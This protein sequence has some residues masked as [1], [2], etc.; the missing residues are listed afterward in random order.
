MVVSSTPFFVLERQNVAFR[1]P[2][3]VVFFQQCTQM[4]PQIV[5]VASFVGSFFVCLVVCLFA[6][7]DVWYD[8]N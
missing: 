6:C 3:M 1:A 2:S 8:G 7:L 5:R 4:V